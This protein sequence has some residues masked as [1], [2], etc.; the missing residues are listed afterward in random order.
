MVLAALC[1]LSQHISH[2]GRQ[3]QRPGTKGCIPL[4]TSPMPTREP[5][6]TF[7]IEEE[8]HLVDLESRGFAA[9]PTELMKACELALGKQVAPEFFRSQIEVGTSVLDDFKAA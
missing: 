4:E 9:A 7:G 3:G 6:F 2:L 8:Y 5:S 1:H